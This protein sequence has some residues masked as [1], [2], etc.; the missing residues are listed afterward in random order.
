MRSTRILTHL[1]AA[2]ALLPVLS[3]FHGTPEGKATRAFKLSKF[4]HDV[5]VHVVLHEMGHALVREF[6]LPILGNEETLADA[7]ATHYLTRHMPERAVDVLVARTESLMSEARKVARD[8]WSVRGEHNSDARRAYQIAA[9]AVAAG[10]DGYRRVAEVVGMTEEEMRSARDYGSE[11]HRSWRRVLAPHRM[12]DGE[13]STETRFAFDG[14]DEL[15]REVRKRGLQ[16]ELRD[17]L[18]RFDWHSQV[19]IRFEGGEGGAAWSRSRR[20]ITVHR[21]YVDRFVAQ[22]K[23]LAKRR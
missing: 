16:D 9:L 23:A 22:G 15:E 6:D 18:D 10:S 3:S 8:E 11:I 4:A 7:F 13:R 12:P 5:T 21:E 19:T 14:D 2:V 17:A 20:T 1:A